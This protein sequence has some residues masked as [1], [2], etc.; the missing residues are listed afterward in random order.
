MDSTAISKLRPYQRQFLEAA[1]RCKALCFGEF[2]LKS[3]RSSP[4]FFNAGRFDH[5]TALAALASALAHRLHEPVAE[6]QSVLAF[7]MLFGPAY[8]GIAIV[9]A[10]AAELAN[11]WS[12][13]LPFAFDRK[14]AKTHGEGGVLI[15]AALAGRV[16][17]VDDVITAGT[18]IAHSIGLIRAAG[19]QPAGVLVALDR[20]ERGDTALCASQQVSE[21]Y[22]IPVLS[23]IDLDTLLAFSADSASLREH[24]IALERYRAQ[25]GVRASAGG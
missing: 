24:A 3:G 20:K 18:S 15:G 4:Y 9:A 12:R 6:G 10:L 11:R 8:K 13:D 2:T 1:L 23:V 17:I 7:D 19:A 5:G 16:L 25:W 14:E 21:R 22:G